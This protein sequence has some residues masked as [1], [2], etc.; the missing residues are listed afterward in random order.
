[1]GSGRYL[2]SLLRGIVDFFRDGGLMLA[3]SLSYFFMM[4]LIPFCLF[5]VAIFGHFLG[6]NEAF[7]KFFSAKL[8]GFFPS[9]TYK[10]TEELK[11]LISYHGLGKFTL[12]LYGI[13]SYQLFSSLETAVN[14]VFKIRVSRPFHVALVRAVFIVTLIMTAIILSFGATSAISIL[15]MAQEILPEEI[16]ISKIA[17]F[18]IGYMIPFVLVFL[19]VAIMYQFLPLRRVKLKNALTGAIFTAVLL[20]AA[21][22][23][24]TFYV[25]KVTHLGTIYGPLSAFVIFLLW[26]YYSSCIFLIGAELVHNLHGSEKKQSKR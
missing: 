11:K 25:V 22:H 5:V 12:L 21:K 20:E 24:F 17:S 10:I 14:T 15:K 19:I 6:H 16:K 13:L 26:V 7:L 18:L 8:T 9:I 4:A 23:L 1:M 2:K 3:G